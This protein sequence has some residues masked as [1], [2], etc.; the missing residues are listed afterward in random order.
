MIYTITLGYVPS[1]IWKQSADRYVESRHGGLTYEHIFLDQHYPLNKKTN[2]QELREINEQHNIKT[3]DAGKNLGLHE[4][5]NY[6]LKQIPLKSEDV[7]IGYDPDSYPVTPGWDMAL[8]T[9]MLDKKIGWASLMAPWLDEPMKTRSI[10][11]R[12]VNQVEVWIQP[13]PIMN[14]ICSWQA[15]YLLKVGGLYEK[16]HWYGGLE[17]WQWESL[18]KNNLQW[19]FLPGWREDHRL[20]WQQDELYKVWKWRYAAEH[21]TQDDFETWLGKNGLSEIKE[22]P[23]AV[24]AGVP[25]SFR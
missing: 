6:C 1:R 14:S 22:I 11:K 7:V 9:A 17:V 2:A 13:D 3:L 21:Q 24:V 23:S 10:K 5:F 4:G 20:H 19:A 25:E 12:F 15:D 18:V 16:L 8:I